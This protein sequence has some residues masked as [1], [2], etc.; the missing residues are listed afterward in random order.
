MNA[1]NPYA[2]PKAHVSDVEDSSEGG[3]ERVRFFT[4]RG[5][6][7]RLRYVAYLFG[8]YLVS[9]FVGG[10]FGAIA[11]FAGHG[12]MAGTLGGIA[13]IP[14]LIYA[15]FITI[16]RSHDMNWSGWSWLWTIV[17]FAVFIWFFKR[18][19]QGRNRFGLPT[20]PNT[21]GV[22]ILAW[23]LPAIFVLGI[24]A[25]IAIPAYSAYVQRAKASQ[26]QP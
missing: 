23:T 9:M 18:G 11:G 6:I 8:G 16:Q 3:T 17:P 1:V 7:G 26:V 14:M 2:P 12:E 4:F 20:P 15:V 25:A 10:I 24:L 19:T 22:H 21:V 5:R 13:S